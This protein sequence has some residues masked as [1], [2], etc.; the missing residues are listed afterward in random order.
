MR[1]VVWLTLAFFVAILV[2]AYVYSQ[3]AHPVFIDVDPAAVH[4][5]HG[6]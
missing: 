6:H 5:T 3:R 4:A 1:L 2:A